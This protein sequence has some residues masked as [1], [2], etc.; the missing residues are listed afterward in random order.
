MLV[1]QFDLDFSNVGNY[2]PTSNGDGG[3]SFGVRAGRGESGIGDVAA[4]LD[5]GRQLPDSDVVVDD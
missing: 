4:G 2:L 3:T 5:R 1:F